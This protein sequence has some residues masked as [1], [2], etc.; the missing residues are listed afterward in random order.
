MTDI[1]SALN[2]E[3]SLGR[4]R[5][6]ERPPTKREMLQRSRALCGVYGD[7]KARTRSRKEFHSWII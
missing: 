3:I 5:S 2:P 7:P 4:T 1:D 6:R